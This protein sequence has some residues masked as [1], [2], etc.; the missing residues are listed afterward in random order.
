MYF[1]LFEQTFASLS[2]AVERNS[3]R[4]VQAVLILAG[5]CDWHLENETLGMCLTPFFVSYA[6]LTRYSARS[7]GD[8]FVSSECHLQLHVKSHAHAGLMC[9]INALCN[10]SRPNFPVG[11]PLPS[12][13]PRSLNNS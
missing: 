9:S 7:P 6:R 2:L 1:R 13:H 4:L 12:S 10:P 8:G 5:Q 11:D 3:R